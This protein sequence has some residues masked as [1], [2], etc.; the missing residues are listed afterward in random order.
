MSL[1][2]WPVPSGDWTA[3]GNG[4]LVPSHTPAGI[5]VILRVNRAGTASVV[6]E[7][8]TNIS[9]DYMIQSPNGQYAILAAAVPGDNNAWMI[10]NF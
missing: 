3:D 8:T 4:I 9:F 10:D 1:N 7:E 6:L 5:P 2:D